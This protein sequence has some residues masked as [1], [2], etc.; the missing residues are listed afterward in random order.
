MSKKQDIKLPKYSGK[1]KSQYFPSTKDLE[2]SQAYNE[3]T[4]ADLQVFKYFYF[5]LTMKESKKKKWVIENN[6][7]ISVP[8][9]AMVNDLHLSKQT[10]SSAI[11][12]LI[13]VGLIRITREGGARISHLVKVL[14]WVVPR[15]E[16]RW[17]LY[18]TKSWEDEVPQAKGNLV[19]VKTRWRKGQ[20][21]REVNSHPKELDQD[22]SRELDQEESISLKK[23]TNGVVI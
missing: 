6:G 23:Y 16:E 15:K 12:K 3:L 8:A 21:G 2:E 11:K 1:N 19:G 17:R 20:S 13:K 7:E 14:Y 4:K 10:I 22:K 5:R 18:P 9:I